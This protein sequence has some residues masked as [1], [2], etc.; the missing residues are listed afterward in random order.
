MKFVKDNLIGLLVLILLLTLFIER[1]NKP[2]EPTPP[3]K[4][5]RDT[6]WVKHDSIVYS[7]PQVIKTI[8]MNYHDSLIYI[9][10][11]NYSKLVLQ[12]QEVV[13]Q[14]LAKN[15]LLDSVRIDTNGYVKIVDTV[16]KN[17]V[18]GRSTQVNVKYPVIKETVTL[19][20]KPVNQVYIGGDIGGSKTSLINQVRA[21][22]IL[23]N[24]KDQIFSAS[25]GL[26]IDG[27]P[28]YGVG[29][30]WKIKLVR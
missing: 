25:V 11:T 19:Y 4:I 1:C 21:G 28:T 20:P 18:V 5:V 3:P 10:D 12:Y 24:K 23:K 8:R 7:K 6:V 30:Y 9:P 26:G 2:V 22:V 17:L 13:N 27:Q 15:I 16:Q 29:S 14:L